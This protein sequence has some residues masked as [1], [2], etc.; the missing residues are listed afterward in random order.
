MADLSALS[1]YQVR[2]RAGLDRSPPPGLVAAARPPLPEGAVVAALGSML[3]AALADRLEQ[4]GYHRVRSDLPHPAL[5]AIEPEAEDYTAFATGC[6]PTGSPGGVEQLLRRC[7][8][9]FSPAE[10]RWHQGD[11]VIDPFRPDLRYPARSD[12]EF[13]VL[14]ARYFTGL[15]SALRRAQAVLIAFDSVE[16]CEAVADGAVL[17]RWPDPFD[18]TQYRVRTLGAKEVYEHIQQ[19]V[20]LLRRINPDAAILL[21]ISPEPAA[22]TTSHRHVLS[23][24]MFSK[25]TLRMAMDRFSVLDGVAYVPA[26]DLAMAT[27]VRPQD[28][29]TDL[30]FLDAIAQAMIDAQP[31]VDTV[32]GTNEASEATEAVTAPSADVASAVGTSAPERTPRRRQSAT[33]RRPA[34]P[35][36]AEPAPAARKAGA[37]KRARRKAAAEGAGDQPGN[38]TPPV[39]AEAPAPE[40]APRRRRPIAGSRRPAPAAPSSAPAVV[41]A[42]AAKRAKRKAAAAVP[43]AVP[44]QKKVVAA[45][46][47]ESGYKEP[48]KRRSKAAD[49]KSPAPEKSAAHGARRQAGRAKKD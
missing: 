17:P 1:D 23:A 42:G 4:R 21:M 45:P 37:A 25:A 13:D 32:S 33:L 5:P 3:A 15:R 6:G 22:A 30:P 36:P 16:I 39:P 47:D 38:A 10:D 19:T 11:L 12:R 28:A 48:K 14:T 49:A 44:A 20:R 18:S 40:A 24:D 43:A 2:D 31:S 41:K 34:S 9:E 35:L 7:L 27:G 29:T 26:L 46:V 8:G